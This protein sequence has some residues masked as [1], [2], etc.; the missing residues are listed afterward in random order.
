VIRDALNYHKREQYFKKKIYRNWNA[1][2]GV[3]KSD[4]EKNQTLPGVCVLDREESS[5]ASSSR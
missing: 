1:G 2:E 5:G 4:F 3:K